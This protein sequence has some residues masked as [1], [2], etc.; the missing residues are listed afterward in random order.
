IENKN[1]WHPNVLYKVNIPAGALFL[2]KNCFT[3][4]FVEEK[5]VKHSHA[6][7]NYQENH[8]SSIVHYHS[9]KVNFRN[10]NNNVVLR[11]DKIRPDYE[12]YFIGNDPTRWASHVRKYEEITYS[13]I[14][15]NIDMKVYTKPP[16]GLKYDFILK[17]GS[18]YK[19]IAM[20]YI[21]A[22]KILIKD[23]NIVIKT[24]VNEIVE[25]QPCAYQMTDSLEVRV[26]CEYSLEGNI[27]TFDFP[28][29]YDNSKTLVIDPVLIFSTY[30]GSTADNWGFTATY[31]LYGNVFSGGIVF[32]VGYPVSPG[33]FQE[34]FGGGNLD[35]GIIK[36]NETGTQRIYA[37]YIG[38]SG[39]EL[40]HSLVVNPNN[41]LLIF[42]TTGSSNFPVTI[43]AYDISF[44][45]GTNLTYDNV[46]YFP[47]G[48]DIYICRLTANGD[49]MLASTY[50]GGSLNDGL[51]FKSYINSDVN[52]LMHGND[53]LYFNYAD[54]ARGEIIVNG[55]N[56]VYVGTCTFSSNFP[57][58][59]GAFQPSSNGKEEGIVFKF[60][61]S[62]TSL[63]WSSYLGGSQ[64]DA[65]Y[66][67]DID[68]LDNV[69][70]AGG[71]AS[72]NFPTTP[73]A[74][75][76]TFQGGTTD[77]FVAHISENGNQLI[78]STY[79]GSSSY[80]QAYFV[81]IDQYR[82]VFITGQ[83]QNAGTNLVYNASYY[84]AN[85]GQYISKFYNELDQLY[86][87]TQFGSGNGSPDISLTAFTVDICNR[88]Y[89]SGWGR[90]WAGTGDYTWDNING[91]KNL[92]VT[93]DA[94]QST[95][96]GQDFYIM[97]LADDAS[98]I[99]YATFFGEQEYSCFYSG[100]DHVDGGTSRFDKKGNI[101]QSVCASCGYGCNG[102][103]TYPNPGVW[104]PNSGG[105]NNTSEWVCNNAVFRFKFMEDLCIADFSMPQ[106][107]CPPYQIN[108]TNTSANATQYY[109]DFGDTFTS[110][111]AS[112]THTYTQ[113]GQYDVTLIVSN[114]TSCNIGD[115]IVKQI[116]LLSNTTDTL[117][118]AE[119]CPN[120]A[121]QIGIEPYP[122]SDI[123]YTWT[124]ATG[125]SATNIPN[126]TVTGGTGNTEITYLLVVS[127]LNCKDSIY[128]TVQFLPDEIQ[129]FA[130]PDTSVCQGQPVTL[131]AYSPD[132]IQSYIWSDS[133]QFTNQLNPDPNIGTFTVTVTDNI[134]YYVRADG[135][136][137]D[138]FDVQ[139]VNLEIYPVGVAVTNDTVIC[140]GDT[141]QLHASSV[142]PGDILQ[143]VWSPQS[144]IISGAN[145]AN[146]VV[147]PQIQTTYYVSV[148]N[149]HGCTDASSVH[150]NLDEVLTTIA[151]LQHALCFGDCNGS[152]SII[153]NSGTE[154]YTYLWNNGLATPS[155]L[156][157]CTGNYSITATDQIGCTDVIN[158]TINQPPL[159]LAEIT[160]TT[161]TLCGF[162]CTGHAEITPSG[163]TS[164]YNILWINNQTTNMITDLCAGEYSVTITDD[165]GC[166]AFKT[167]EIQDTSDLSI[168]LQLLNPLLCYGDCYGIAII[169]PTEGNPPYSYQWSNG[170]SNNPVQNLCAGS[171]SVTV[172]D[173]A[174]CQRV[175]Y[176][177][178]NQ[179]S[180]LF[181]NAS[182][183][184]IACHGE[185][186]S[187]SVTASGG[188]ENYS[189]HWTDITGQTI[190]NTTIAGNLNEGMYYVEVTDANNCLKRDSITLLEPDSLVFDSLISPTLCPNT[191]TGSIQILS[192]GGT[193]PYSYIWSDGTHGSENS[194]L[195]SGNYS[196]TVSD[197][198][199]CKA[200]ED[201]Y[202]GISDY[203]PP[204]DIA[205]EDSAVFPG[206]STNLHATTGYIVYDWSPEATMEFPNTPN[207]VVTPVTT[208]KYNLTIL[209]SS[210]CSESDSIII[211]IK[212]VLCD[213]PYIYVPNA[214]TPNGDGKNDKLCVYSNM[215]DELYFTIYDRWGE[216]MFMT[217]NINDGWDGTYQGHECDPAVFVYYLNA[218]CWDNQAF[219][220]K[221][222]ITLIR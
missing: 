68:E 177:S 35:V 98:G 65:I 69:Y 142:V 64:D 116:V 174:G 129:L 5:D 220:K 43:G 148:T 101:Y 3:Y 131:N 147:A 144:N 165:N 40:P 139:S 33:A 218:T 63:L 216:C 182:S 122:Y 205:A 219:V 24:S 49:D 11:H 203:E 100:H 110:T 155:G 196:V 88:I 59:A 85:S 55:K 16:K 94:V 212:D 66:S 48:I 172:A 149:Q 20:E 93:P 161:S 106:I 29:G 12:N 44:N 185:T 47:Q 17:P 7:H 157:L 57:V 58:T 73:G 37:T 112:P 103:P 67:L 21:G 202:V 173:N 78:S 126:P 175:K 124:P 176:F 108:F 26:V 41:E 154:P 96:D 187:A 137:C 105:A 14:Y 62:L 152:A 164:P 215:I 181:V 194:E 201:F 133:P 120:D 123:T 206:Q 150:V 170:I 114:P 4:N 53:S 70:V 209:D 192:E 107:V 183:P 190:S 1:Q 74:F 211:Y 138:A 193:P 127:Y 87:S 163:G 42:G 208:T 84:V 81:R 89:L 83:T 168:M 15:H 135:V 82:N 118:E 162:Q 90:E 121:I 18:D 128:Q 2:E 125:L 178:V 27:I 104:S 111:A 109:W 222:N 160:D 213:E 115:T 36:Y 75:H 204:L 180:S 23:G 61:G 151:E 72:N 184:G 132:E 199:N 95:T 221:G 217:T 30:T 56:N 117:P 50:I 158:L 214:F 9:Y 143:Y 22:D 99:N 207:P 71:T 186:T 52:I 76:A 60:N 169:T 31:D 28:G 153:V 159:L 39:C 146:P 141:V 179:P 38:G 102:F 91:T 46:V 119:T 34:N 113:P 200:M 136:S 13:D 130:G 25:L 6:H 97:V 92:T 45:G 79:F 166:T 134:T 156:G 51:N 198:H 8:S 167:L 86:W 32:N 210:G 80:D 195:C 171:Y 10:S 191:C 197:N 140:K 145:T 54:C 189:Y 77:G 19:N 188:T